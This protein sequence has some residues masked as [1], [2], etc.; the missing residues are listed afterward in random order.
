MRAHLDC[1]PCFQRQ[2][3]QA[4]RFVSDDEDLHEE[5]LR[6]VMKELMEPDWKTSPPELARRVHRI[7][8]E[9]TGAADPYREAKVEANRAALGMYPELKE[10][11]EKAVDP[12]ETAVRL[13][14][15]GNIIDLGACEG[16]DLERTVREVLVKPF[17]V[18]DY[19]RFVEALSPT[20]TIIYL[21]DNS[22][23]VV[24]DRLLLETILG[25]YDVKKIIFVVKGAPIINDATIT[26][27]KEA[28]I[29][30]LPGIEFHN[31]GT[32]APGSGHVRESDEFGKFLDIG[33]MIISKGQGNFE[34]LSHRKDV[35]FLLM[36]KCPLV[37]LELGARTG[38]I[39][40]KG[41]EY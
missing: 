41:G 5:I 18:N 20:D 13:A 16:F 4:A 15:A 21:A 26:E 35:F 19:R 7:V 17:K 22:G 10:K 38:D 3:L 23:E 31:M 30:R 36:A 37:A 12:L 11:V 6:E 34:G 27:A 29:D 33:D 25:R 2:A 39:I 14:I 28:G 32:G 1:I 24:F 8:R 40:L 9:R